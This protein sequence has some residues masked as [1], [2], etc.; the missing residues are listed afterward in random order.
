MNKI[1]VS[2]L[3][4]EKLNSN[5]E[6]PRCLKLFLNSCKNT[7]T[8][9]TYAN[10]LSAFLKHVGKDH[11][12]L[13][14]LSDSELNQTLEDYVMFCS[15]NDRY[16]VSSIRG[17]VA[18]IEKFLFINDRTVNK[19]KLMMFL[20]EAK[21]TS[22]RAITTEEVRLLL[23]AS[24]NP[25]Q[26]A[27]IHIFSATGCRPTALADLK[28]KDIEFMAHDFT[29]VLFYSGSKNEF[30]HFCHP[31]ATNAINDYLNNRKQTG[32]ELEPE[33]YLFCKLN[34]IGDEKGRMS[35][36]GIGSVLEH[37][38]KYAGISRVK[39][40]EKRFDLP[41]CNGLRNRFN[42]I[43][44]RN[45]NIPYAVAESFMDHKLRMESSYFKP[46]RLE[47]LNEYKKA[48]A[49]LVI[50]KEALLK[51]ENDNKQKHIE[52]LESGKDIQIKNMQLQIDSLM[53]MQGTVREL[54]KL[55]H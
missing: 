26:R 15:D 8:R 31:E 41:V 48:V 6:S 40:N 32:E 13:L 24:A 36:A 51:L 33:S 52:E 44:K 22:Q 38:M 17:I 55:K 19:K 10:H 25:R 27:L 50:S 16:A 47:L 49:E 7:A 12:S 11:E 14:A 4:Q 37:L 29:S 43:L 23:S 30:Q 9:E 46:T 39:Q 20:P 3:N 18:G 2:S 35:G 28:M 53:S 5:V 21:K 45:S 54:M 1:P 34:C 42:T